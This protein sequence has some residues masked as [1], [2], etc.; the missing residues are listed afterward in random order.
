MTLRTPPN[1]AD[2]RFDISRAHHHIRSASLDQLEAQPC[3]LVRSRVV[4]HP[5]TKLPH[6]SAI[7]CLEKAY[8]S[9]H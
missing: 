2:D 3:S 7:V 9:K 6:R 4:T 1:C 8:H 5:P